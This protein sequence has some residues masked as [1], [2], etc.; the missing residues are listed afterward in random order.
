[1]RKIKNFGIPEAIDYANAK[2]SPLYIFSFD[3]NEGFFSIKKRIFGKKGDV[4][5]E[6]NHADENIHQSEIP[7][8]HFKALID[9]FNEKVTNEE[10]IITIKEVSE[11][12]QSGED[13]DKF[14]SL[15]FDKENYIKLQ[16]LLNTLT[17]RNL[18]FK[19]EKNKPAH[20]LKP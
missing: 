6:N 1:M 3:K 11:G 2:H 7:T 19:V 15:L 4:F 17:S 14:N 8:S 20:T 16:R 18:I 9:L 12:K 10:K 13:N 5:S